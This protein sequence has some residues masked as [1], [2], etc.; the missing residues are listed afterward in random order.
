M[1][2]HCSR[3]TH[4]RRHPNPRRLSEVAGAAVSERDVNVSVLRLPQVRDTARQG[5]IT[6]AVE[7]A[8]EKGASEME[9]R[10][11]RLLKSSAEA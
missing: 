11:G 1:G 2:K 7:V 3:S 9:Y 10:C 6:C 5:L 8:R 4:N